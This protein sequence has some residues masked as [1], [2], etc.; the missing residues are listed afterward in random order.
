MTA[1]T[2]DRGAERRMLTIL[3]VDIV[4]STSLARRLDQEDFAELLNAFHDICSRTIDRFEGRVAKDLGD[5]FA[6]HFGWPASHEQDA[7]RAVLAGLEMV[8]AVKAISIASGERVRV[9]VGIATGNVVVS[10]VKRATSPH[11]H[12]AF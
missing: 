5:G 2:D 9:H 7:E 8:N 4:D 3:V 11:V 10:D 6:A 1:A 12:E